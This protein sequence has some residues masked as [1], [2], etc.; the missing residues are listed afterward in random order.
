MILGFNIGFLEIDLVDIIDILLFAFL[1]QQV[2]KLMRG[3]V[4]IKIFLGFLVLYLVYL[5]VNAADMELLSTVLGQFMGVGVLAVI[6]LFQQEIRKF[7]LLL[8]RTHVFREGSI[9][10]NIKS[11]WSLNGNNK[12]SEITPVI[13]AA[14]TLGGSNTGALIVISRNS[15]LKFYA[16]SGDR[17]DAKVSKRLLLAI[18]NKFSPLHDGAVIVYDNRIIA[19]RCIL[20]VTERDDLPAQY[21]LRHRAAVGMS[22]NTDVL[23]LVVSEETGQLTTVRN[24][25]ISQNLSAQELRKKIND[26]LFENEN[27]ESTGETVLKKAKEEAKKEE[28]V[29]NPVKEQRPEQPVDVTS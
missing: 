13:E 12:K 20:P 6:I 23:I 16:E 22:E 9:L 2:Y 27:Y 8:G 7:L 5:V 17:L 29:T 11:I 10:E 4:A 19:A 1:L 3:S 14:K 21:G 24:G 26:Y 18:F 25:V 28:K 15:E